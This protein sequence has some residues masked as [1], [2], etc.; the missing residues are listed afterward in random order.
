MVKK[1]YATLQE[2]QEGNIIPKDKQLD[3][4]GIA[5]MAKSSMADSTRAALQKILLEDILEADTISQLKVI[6]HLAILE[7]KIIESIHSGS[8]DFYKP[9]TIKSLN[10]YKDPMRQQGIKAS[11]VWNSI[12]ERNLEAINLEERNAIFVAKCNITKNSLEK[13]KDSFPYVYEKAIELLEQPAFKGKID[14]IA[15]PRDADVPEW[16]VELIDYKIIVN[17]NISGFPIESIG[18]QRMGNTNVNYTNI[19]QL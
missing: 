17:D 8:K 13:I 4:K 11:V 2:V 3:I 1:A 12:K 15:I 10:S 7:K 16:L 18:L 14:A 6:K 9:V 5:S 19:L